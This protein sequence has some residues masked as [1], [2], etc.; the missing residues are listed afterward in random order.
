MGTAPQTSIASRVAAVP[1]QLHG[2]GHIIEPCT[3]EEASAGL[4]FGTMVKNG[5]AQNLGKLPAAI[6]DKLAGIVVF[7][8]AYNRDTE[9]DSDGIQPKATF[10]LLRKG[11]ISVLLEENVA[12]GGAVRVRCVVEGDEQKGAF[13]TTEDATDCIDISAFAQWRTSGSAGGTAVL[14]V[15]M[16]N[17]ALAVADDGS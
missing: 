9:L 12:V 1:G 16:T 6:T 14:E 10:G 15:D 8:H 2:S 17:A 5:T 4:P 11:Q 7:N 3:N 13:R